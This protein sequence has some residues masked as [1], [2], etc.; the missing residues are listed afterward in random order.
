M[1]IKIEIDR[2]DP[3]PP[4]YQV[5]NILQPYIESLKPGQKIPTEYELLVGSNVCRSTLARAI[6]KLVQEGF[7][8]RIPGKGTFIA[9]GSCNDRQLNKLNTCGMLVGDI[10]NPYFKE[11]IRGAKEG[12]ADKGWNV[13]L[14]I[15]EHATPEMEG[16]CIEKLL[17][18]P[19]KGL[20]I[21]PAVPYDDMNAFAH[22]RK[23]NIPYVLLCPIKTLR[24]NYVLNDDFMGAYMAVDYLIKLGHKQISIIV[25]KATTYYDIGRLKGYRKA[26]HDNGLT[27]K[28]EIICE[29][30]IQPGDNLTE[31]GYKKAKELLAKGKKNITAC[32][33]AGGDQFAIGVIKAFLENGLRIPDDISVVG[34]DDIEE[35]ISF[36]PVPLTTVHQPRYEIGKAAAELL[37]DCIVEDRRNIF[38]KK[39][40]KPKFIV[41]KSCAC[42]KIK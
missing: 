30:D 13:I 19:L 17:D 5:Y 28:K 41:R 9:E 25:N 37:Y 24:A 26:L 14:E 39:V 12:M 33:V 8:F 34:F 1:T 4:Y 42:P 35:I 23:L 27:V 36:S 21:V 2:T 15:L 20:I 29:Y 6:N 16:K 40:L 10:S 18:L 31:I 11:V 3:L 32:F 38:I 7:L 22:F